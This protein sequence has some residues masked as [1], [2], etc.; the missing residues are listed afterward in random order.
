MVKFWT[1]DWSEHSNDVLTVKTKTF[2]SVSQTMV[3]EYFSPMTKRLQFAG[4]ILDMYKLINRQS[5]YKI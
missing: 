4:S 1:L 5:L 2:N 3:C